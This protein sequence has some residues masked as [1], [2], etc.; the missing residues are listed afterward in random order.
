MSGGLP[1]GL[2]T[3][4]DSIEGEIESVDRVAVED[5]TK[6]WK[7][8]MLRMMLSWREKDLLILDSLLY[9]QEPPCKRCWK[10]IGELF[11]E[12]LE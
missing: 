7:G 12:N 5:I 6:L 11:L 9:Q 4:T 2:V 1:E 10:K 3:S 8:R